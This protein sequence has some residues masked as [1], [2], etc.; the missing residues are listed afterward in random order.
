MPLEPGDLAPDDLVV[1]DAEGGHV[2]LASMRGEALL[3]IYLRHLG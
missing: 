3:L 1:V 2:P